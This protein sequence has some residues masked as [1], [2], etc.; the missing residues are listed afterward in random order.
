MCVQDLA[1][2]GGFGFSALSGVAAL[3]DSGAMDA[4]PTKLLFVCLGNICRSPTGEGVMRHVVAEAGVADRF[5]IDSAGTGSWHIGHAPDPRSTAAAA[6][7]GITLA[8]Q[9]RQVSS[10]DFAEFDLLL[11]ADRL[12]FRDLTE[13]APSDEDE[14][15]IHMLRSFDP[16]STPDDLD[17]PDPYY[18][19]ADG[20]NEVI[21]LVTAACEGLLEDVLAG[22]I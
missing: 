17:V 4:P 1:W 19:G 15:K 16:M 21:D 22:K 7:R 18:G 10:N 6:A 11:A 12:N 13:I 2:D 3:S 20:F 9:A 5:V 14:A 8:G